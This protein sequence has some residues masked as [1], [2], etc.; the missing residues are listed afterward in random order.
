MYVESILRMRNNEIKNIYK[1]PRM[2]Y[3]EKNNKIIVVAEDVAYF[4]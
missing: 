2:E 4:F 3:D 1:H